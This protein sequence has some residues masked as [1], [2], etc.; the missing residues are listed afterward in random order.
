M[1]KKIITKISEGLGNQLFM[2]ANS[3][4]LSKKFNLEF[5]IDPYSGYFKK[6][7]YQFMLSKFN[8]S[9]NIASSNWIFANKYRNFFKK[10]YIKFDN[11]KINKSFLFE[12]KNLDKSTFF[13]P[14]DI[15]NTNKVFYVDG[16]FESEKYF[17]DYRNDLLNE[18]TLIDK[19]FYKNKY[20]D[21]IKNNNVVSICIRQNRFSERISNIN[22]NISKIK[23]ENF[24]KDTVEYIYRSID[25]IK[26]K[27]DNPKFLLWSNDFKN[28]NQYFPSE[29]FIFVDNEKDKII[30]D[31]YLLTQCKNFII[32]PST[33]NWWGAWLSNEENKICIRP[34]N[35]NPSNNIDFW[36]ESWISI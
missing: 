33:F 12:K 2:Y 1:K 31:F 11:L 4:S 3:Y 13:N 29:N 27:I 24:V 32:A 23:S 21:L 19:N 20:L 17:I 28:L 10:I 16:N 36:P 22:S 35:L 34:K 9:S 18:F 5:Y 7:V 8:I 15:F 14:I 6:N 25:F 26:T 30:S